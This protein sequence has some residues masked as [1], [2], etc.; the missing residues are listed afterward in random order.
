MGITT[1]LHL[2]V[3]L[4]AMLRISSPPRLDHLQRQCQCR[5]TTGEVRQL[6]LLCYRRPL[7]LVVLLLGDS[8]D[9]RETFQDHQEIFQD[10]LGDQIPLIVHRPQSDHPATTHET[11]L[12]FL[13]SRQ[14]LLLPEV[15]EGTVV[16]NPLEIRSVKITIDQ[17]SAVAT[18]HRHSDITTTVQAALIH[19]LSDSTP[20]R[21]T[22]PPTRKLYREE[23]F[24][25]QE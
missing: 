14:R 10:R 16:E 25:R 15:L 12:Q 5:H 3:H 4:A 2:L 17:A 22:S 13:P 21:N 11:R 8:M 24:C 7:D 23:S 9:H 18:H 19:A 1:V 6:A 20:Q